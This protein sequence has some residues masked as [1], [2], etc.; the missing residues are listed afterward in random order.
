M[1][2]IICS[3][4]ILLIC[5]D[6]VAQ[7]EEP[8]LSFIKTYDDAQS[9]MNKYKYMLYGDSL[10]QEEI[11]DAYC[12]LYYLG[13]RLGMY[14]MKRDQE[15]KSY[16]SAI[17]A[18]STVEESQLNSL[19]KEISIFY[20]VYLHLTQFHTDALD[21]YY[22]MNFDA[23]NAFLDN[24]ITYIF[25]EEDL[26]CI[27]Y[28]IK[29]VKFVIIKNLSE[30]FAYETK[31]VQAKTGNSKQKERTIFLKPKQVFILSSN[32]NDFDYIKP[33]KLE[34]INKYYANN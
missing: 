19:I 9:Y 13:R 4:T 11:V 2:K 12:N 28:E 18:R 29:E 33:T 32:L 15:Y 7:I 27:E 5:F 24:N 16:N 20:N 34:I 6:I 31:A 30:N 14:N 3:L 26:A 22:W 23:Y 17:K 8:D 21:Y 10:T 1:K 25:F